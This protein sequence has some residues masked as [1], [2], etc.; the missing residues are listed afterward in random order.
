MTYYEPQFRALVKK[1]VK[2][3]ILGECAVVIESQI[4]DGGLTNKYNTRMSSLLP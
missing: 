2:F 4:D 1:D 3:K